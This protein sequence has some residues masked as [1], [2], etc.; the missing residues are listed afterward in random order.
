ME[1]VLTLS[2]LIEQITYKPIDFTVLGLSLMLQLEWTIHELRHGIIGCI[3]V[4]CL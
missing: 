2:T 3:V 4:K 1:V